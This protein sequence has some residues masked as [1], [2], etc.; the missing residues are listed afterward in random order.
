M[1]NKIYTKEQA[2]KISERKKCIE[3]CRENKKS[4]CRK[5]AEEL[6]A[7]IDINKLLDHDDKAYFEEV[8]NTL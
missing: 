6:R 1:S 2:N 4:N 3:T 5:K 7:N 8:F